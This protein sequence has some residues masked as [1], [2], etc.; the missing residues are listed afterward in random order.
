VWTA[1]SKVHQKVADQNEEN[2]GDDYSAPS[3]QGKL[4]LER[5]ILGD[6]LSKRRLGG[7]F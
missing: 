1:D 2:E 5:R 3:L 7:R 4:W 6:A